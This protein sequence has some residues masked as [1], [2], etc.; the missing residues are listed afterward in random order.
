VLQADTTFNVGFAM[1]P[2]AIVVLA[3]S[4]T[5]LTSRFLASVGKIRPGITSDLPDKTGSLNQQVRIW[6]QQ[7]IAMP[8]T[9]ILTHLQPAMMLCHTIPI[10]G[11]RS[12]R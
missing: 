3:R 6:G 12:F 2:C 1:S 9:D 7:R 5:V 4:A 8:L 10:C 11:E